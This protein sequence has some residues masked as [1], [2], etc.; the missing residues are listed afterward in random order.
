MIL[1]FRISAEISTITIILQQMTAAYSLRK[2][3]CTPYKAVVK[4]KKG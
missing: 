3:S 2:M 4:Y 1:E